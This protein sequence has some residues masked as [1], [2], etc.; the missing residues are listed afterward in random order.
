MHDLF[1]HKVLGW[2]AGFVCR[3]PIWVL[4]V[5]AVLAVVCIGVT[6]KH[7]KFQSDRNAL[8]SPDL[9]WN[10]HFEDW[11][12]SFP[13]N[14]DLWVVVDSGPPAAADRDDRLAK[15]HAYID[16]LGPAL[17][18]HPDILDAV[19]AFE[20][21]QFSPRTLRL[22]TMD[23]VTQQLAQIT[24]AKPLLQ[25]PTPGHLLGQIIRGLAGQQD[26]TDLETMGQSID[27]LAQ[28][29]QAIEHVLAADPPDR[30]PLA[31][32]VIPADE[33]VPDHEY[34]TSDNHRL[35]FIRVTPNK[36][37]GSINALAPAI[38]AI[39]QLIQEVSN[40]HPGIE[41]GLTGVDVIE[42]DETD[43]A[44][45]DSTVASIVASILILVLLITGFHSWRVPLLAMVALVIGIA[46]SFGFLTLVVGHL[47]VISVVFVVI[48]LG[49]GIAFG[50]HIAS[51]IELV[52]HDYPDG[53]KGFAPA[54]HHSLQ[55]VGPGVITGAV[56]TAAAFGTI[57]LTDFQGVVE[58]GIIAG[59]G[60]LLC[61]VAMLSV[62]PA[63][64]RLC[65]VSHGHFVPMQARLFN[66]FEQRWVMP[67]VHWPKTTLAAAC[68]LTTIA[69]FAAVQTRFDYDLLKLQPRGVPSVLWQERVVR[70]G[71][72]S[73]WAAVS[74]VD[75]LEQ[76][77]QRKA[78]LLS[79]PTIAQVR[80]IG[81]LCPSNEQEKIQALNATY[82]QLSQSLSLALG[83][84][85]PANGQSPPDLA[86][87]LLQIQTLWRSAAAGMIPPQLKPNLDALGRA[88][89]TTIATY[90]QLDPPQRTTR[91]AL[92]QA[93]YDQWRQQ[94]A[95][96]I[97]GALDTSPLTPADVPHELLRP[98]IATTGPLKGKMALEIFPRVNHEGN[99]NGVLDPTFLSKFIADLH[100]VDPDATG[101]ITQ[102]YY[103]AHLI[104]RSY[105]LAGVYALLAV[106]VL[107]WIDFRSIKDAWVSLVPVMVGFALTLGLMWVIG[108]SLN[109]ANIIVLPLMF[110]IGVDSGVHI[111]HRYRQDP[112]T[113]PL[114]LTAGTGKGITLTSFTTMIGFGVMIFASHRGISSLGFVLFTGIGLTM[115][116]CWIIMPAWLELHAQRHH[117][118]H[119][120]PTATD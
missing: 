39:R 23:Q 32:L 56:T 116:A 112:T 60:V 54:L 76:A 46:W 89:D 78:Q 102:V 62:F 91:L 109:P 108:M 48:L 65:A 3:R 71:E 34:L 90:K 94:T 117:P 31:A 72:Q 27:G 12:L 11:R 74:C 43:A 5:A 118:V 58:M 68:L 105:M 1:R 93:E 35:F 96:Q 10:K 97:A 19:W 36:Q 28:L 8:L 37:A 13:G 64:L 88:I 15:V 69:L 42:A 80:G 107:V 6:A 87:Q 61:L 45:H 85:K 4:S 86:Q 52:R 63:M 26:P 7:L 22:Q 111:L 100:T 77:R 110:G 2:W 113:R 67:F 16:E 59:A 83:K 104:Q 41:S 114:G 33:Q 51:G 101:V 20:V 47:Q 95:H 82:Q 79:L 9:D 25:S 44:T 50:I 40:K 84:T 38:A 18:A 81:I 106:F 21:S 73:I 17:V 99:D 30:P 24:Q 57:A 70:D 92:L 120:P 75:S 49:L 103:S 119:N 98:Y 14:E 53:L 66:L 29:I 115:L 55:T